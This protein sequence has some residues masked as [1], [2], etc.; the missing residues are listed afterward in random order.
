MNRQNVSRR[1]FLGGALL[2]SVAP[3]GYSQRHT[4]TPEDF[5]KH[6]LQGSGWPSDHP[7]GAEA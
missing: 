6:R 5:T 3:Y 7:G 4:P 2:G 1:G